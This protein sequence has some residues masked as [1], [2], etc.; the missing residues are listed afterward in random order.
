MLHEAEAVRRASERLEPHVVVEALELLSACTRLVVCIGTGTSGLVAAKLAA[1]FTV[2][3]TPAVFLYASNALHGGL[4]LI[5]TG[6][7]AIVVSNSGRTDETLQVAQRLK[8]LDIPVIALTGDTQAPLAQPAD[9]VLDASVTAEACP[10][11]MVPTASAAV[12]LAMGDA[13][14]MSLAG[15]RG[16]SR[17]DLARVHPAGHLGARARGQ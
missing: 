15:R 1:T 6:D 10:L 17:G 12:T 5:Q 13:L 3:G 7:I 14:A 16:W 4:G 11:E 2:S 8:E 9:V